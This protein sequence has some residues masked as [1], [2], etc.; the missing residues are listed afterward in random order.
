MHTT[1]KVFGG[2]GLLLLLTSPLTL[3]I[4]SGSPTFAGAKAV[5]GLALIGV[6][7]AT[8]Y[9]RLFGP[10]ARAARRS[11]G[12]A[13]SDRRPMG[14]G[15]RASFFFLSTVLIALFAIAALSAVNYIA[16]RR[17]KSW[18]LTQKK[19]YTLAPQ[20]RSTLAGLKEPIKAIGFI[21]AKHPAYDP[22][23]QLFHRYHDE[24]DKF[25][26]EFKDPARNP[27][28]AARY[29]LKDGQTTVVLVKGEGAQESHSALNI[30]SEQ[31]LTN[32]LVKLSSVGEQKV[33]YLVGHGEWPLERAGETPSGAEGSVTTANELRQSLLQEGYSPQTL[34]L[35]EQQNE[36]PADASAVLIGG[37]R[38]PF[39][40]AERNAVKKYL[41]E[42]GRVLYFAEANAEPGLDALL[43]AYGVQVDR[44][45]LA[46][47]KVNPTS[48]YMIVSAFFADHEITRLLKEMKLNVEFPSARGLTVL[49]QGLSEGVSAL[50]I[51][52]TSPFA[53]EELVPNDRPAPSQGEKTGQ[54]PLVAVST[55]STATAPKKRFDEARLVVFGDSELLVDALWGH[56]PNRNLVLN[57]LAW[58]TAQANKITI[59]P[60]DRDISTLDIDNAMMS[61]LRFVAMD[62]L[63]LSLIGLG[64]AIWLSRRSK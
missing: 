24:S 48:P 42:G 52:L 63:P 57:S 20:T 36:I 26:Y 39:S 59:R 54:I 33:Y 43:A 62:L 4:T 6:Y 40:D 11:Q 14:Q 51:V 49:K 45:L 7:V 28:L 31:E 8:H 58:A 19:I 16:A 1:G 61:K 18:D 25:V 35:A 13:G 27:D 3:M 47:D 9:H 44:G 55:R 12:E 41:D 32:A 29:Q 53:W 15:A 10:D 2:L 34:N 38:S 30:I 21:S 17:N 22:L 60:P 50:P 56:E 64:L 46:D 23:E 37:A 5:L